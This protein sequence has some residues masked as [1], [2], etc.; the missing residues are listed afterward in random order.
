MSSQTQNIEDQEIPRHEAS[1]HYWSLKV[2]NHKDQSLK[3]TVM[4]ITGIIRIR[5]FKLQNSGAS[6]DIL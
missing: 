1:S 6:T 4:T 2:K 3:H 5:V